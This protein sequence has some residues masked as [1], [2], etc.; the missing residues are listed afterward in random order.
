MPGDQAREWRGERRTPFQGSSPGCSGPWW[1]RPSP[2][3]PRPRPLPRPCRLPSRSPGRLEGHPRKPGST[4]VQPRGRPMA[5]ERTGRSGSRPPPLLR[6]APPPVRESSPGSLAPRRPPPR[7]CPP[8]P[9][10]IPPPP[11]PFPRPPVAPRKGPGTP[12]TRK[13]STG[14]GW[15]PLRLRL[16]SPPPL[17]PR[18]SRILAQ[19]PW[20]SPGLRRPLLPRGNTPGSCRPSTA[21][22]PVPRGPGGPRD[23]PRLP[24]GMLPYPRAG[25]RPV[26]HPRARPLPD[27]PRPPPSRDPL[28][29]TPA[30]RIHRERQPRMAPLRPPPPPEA[31]APRRP[32]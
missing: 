25:C 3:R 21:H 31:G 2:G 24:G 1:P 4:V 17:R 27:I 23:T 6:R 32:S 16:P 7:P 18:R 5:C 22:R 20:I 14:P 19:A 10:R 30:R 9:L 15:A 12:S 28:P 8:R 29:D 26:T 11:E 13:T